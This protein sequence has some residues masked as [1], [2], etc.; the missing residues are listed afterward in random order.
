VKLF[1]RL[2]RDRR[3]P[4]YLKL[5]PLSAFAYGLMPFDLLPEAL[6]PLLG[7]LDDLFLIALAFWA[8]LRL[9][10]RDVV[11]EHGR[12]IGQEHRR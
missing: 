2:L 12:Q 3:V 7:G 11:M 10:P 1:F 8:F 5:I 4:F 9:S 6:V